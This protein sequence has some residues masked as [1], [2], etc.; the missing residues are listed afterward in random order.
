MR[1]LLAGRRTGRFSESL[2][3]GYRF[4]MKYRLA[5]HGDHASGADLPG[6]R[7]G[8]G[9]F[10]VD[11]G[12]G[13][14]LYVCETRH[15]RSGSK[16]GSRSRSRSTPSARFAR[17]FEGVHARTG[18]AGS[19]LPV[20]DSPLRPYGTVDQR[21]R[22]GVPVSPGSKSCNSFV[23]HILYATSVARRPHLVIGEGLCC[24]YEIAGRS[25]SR[26]RRSDSPEPL[27]DGAVR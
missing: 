24:A 1:F 5:S 27:R 9:R 17:S 25:L 4:K 2:P 23:Q 7:G 16:R 6:R 15:D 8:R 12:S 26:S 13:G 14:F 19:T 10:G 11:L 21:P 22:G 3:M 18:D 20:V